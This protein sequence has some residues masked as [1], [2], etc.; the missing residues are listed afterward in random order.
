MGVVT[1]TPNMAYCAFRF[2]RYFKMWQFAFYCFENEMNT[3]DM[4]NGKYLKALT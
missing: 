1:S 2:D 3:M 4:R